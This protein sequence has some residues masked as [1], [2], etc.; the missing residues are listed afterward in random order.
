[1]HPH[2][3]MHIHAHRHQFTH[4]FVHAH[5]CT[6]V[7]THAHAVAG[8]WCKSMPTQ[9]PS[10]GNTTSRAVVTVTSAGM[11]VAQR[12]WQAL[13]LRTVVALVGL[14]CLCEVNAAHQ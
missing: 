1:M 2:T 14:A 13:A 9:A 5:T 6:Y 10:L 3:H 7:R 12:S 8:Y 4:E 11:P